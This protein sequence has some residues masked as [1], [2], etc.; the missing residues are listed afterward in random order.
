MA[1]A[2]VATSDV[3]ALWAREPQFDDMI[4]SLRA[5]SKQPKSILKETREVV[6]LARKCNDQIV[7]PQ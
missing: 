6:A 4:C 5:I 1:T 7:R 2:M 3:K